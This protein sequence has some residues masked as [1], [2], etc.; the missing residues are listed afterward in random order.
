MKSQRKLVIKRTLRRFLGG[1]L[2]LF[3]IIPSITVILN[4]LLFIMFFPLGVYTVLTWPWTFLRDVPDPFHPGESLYWLT[5]IIQTGDNVLLP[6]LHRWGILDTAFLIAGSAT[7]LF[8]FVTWL[9]NLRKGVITGGIYRVVRHPQ[10]LGLIL[11]TLGISIRSLRPM[12][13]IAWLTMTLGYLI[14]ASL[15]EK[16]LLKSYSQ[17]YEKYTEKTPFMLPFIRVKIHRVLSAKY[18]YR[19]V[20]LLTLYL[21]SIII[22]VVATRSFVVALRGVFTQ[23]QELLLY[24]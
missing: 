2:A 1:I 23:F 7:F 12:S 22:V 14:L 6:S 9:M 20:L 18:L 5:Y 19:Y 17:T 24:L 21:F 4:P 10:Y 13:L 16:D 3:D 15:E 11:A 8:A